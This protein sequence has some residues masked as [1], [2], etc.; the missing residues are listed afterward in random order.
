MERTYT[1]EEL[2]AMKPENRPKIEFDGKEYDNYQATQEQRRIER[3]VRKEK[4][5]LA[6]FEAGGHDKDV[7]NSKIKLQQLNKKY[8]EFSKAAGLP[9]QRE[10]MEILYVA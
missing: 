8:R 1:D 9:L 2:D 3:A 7:E 6:A 10:R 4:R 5:R